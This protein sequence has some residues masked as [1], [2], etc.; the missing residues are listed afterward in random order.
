LED[1]NECSSIPKWVDS[2]EAE[3]GPRSRS[4]S[5]SIKALDHNAN[6]EEDAAREPRAAVVKECAAQQQDAT[7]SRMMAESSGHALPRMMDVPFVES[8]GGSDDHA[9][10]ALPH[11]MEA[12]NAAREAPVHDSA[13]GN[14]ADAVEATLAS[15]SAGVLTR[16][17]YACSAPTVAF[18]HTR[19]QK[20]SRAPTRLS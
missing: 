13:A 15:E 7:N 14:G 16:F 17:P 19:T 20:T 18:A 10:D 1:Y 8:L 4:V 9:A 12:S 11:N 2:H 6:K 3:V 5:P